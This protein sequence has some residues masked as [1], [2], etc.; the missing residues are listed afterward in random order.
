M[1][2]R[3]GRAFLCAVLIFSATIGCKG[4]ASQERVAA[5]EVAPGIENARRALKRNWDQLLLDQQAK[6]VHA[7]PIERF[8][9]LEAP[10]AGI[11]HYEALKSF[12]AAN[13][14][15]PIFTDAHGVP[16]FRANAVVQQARDA[17]RHS[18][19]PEKY[20]R[21]GLA[22]RIQQQ[23]ELRHAWKQ[24]PLPTLQD[25]D[26][27]TIEQLLNDPDIQ[28]LEK[29]LP[30]VLD[31][32][33]GENGET[34]AI[35][36]LGQA[37]H[38]RLRLRRA[39]DGGDAL[40]ELALADMWLDWAYDMR[41]G[42]WE[43][44]DGDAKKEKQDEIRL[45]ALVASMQSMASA[46]DRAAADTVV[47]SK[48]PTY[49]Q[50]GRL[51]EARVKYQAMVA[52][53][54]WPE[55][56]PVNLARGSSGAV[57][58]ELKIRLQTEGYFHG[59]INQSFDKDLEDAVKSYQE[60]HQMEANGRSSAAFWSSINVSAEDRLAQL[61]LTIQRWRESRI[62]DDPYYVLI[63]IPDFH[64]E[65]WRNGVLERRMKIVVGNTQRECRGGKMV[66]VNATPIQTAVMNHVVLNPYWNVPQRI[67][68]E[69]ILPAF[70]KNPNYFEE[71][72]YEQVTADNGAIMVRQVPG[73]QNAL[74]K[75]KFMFPNEHDTYMHDTPRKV[76]F[77]P[78]MRAFSHGCM[79]VQ[80][81]L[82]FLEHLLTNDE[83][84]DKNSIDRIFAGGREYRMNLRT[85][86]PVHSE[87]YVVRVD[88]EGRVH[89]MADI[90]RHDRERLDLRF[91]REESCT[92]RQ[93]PA[94]LR[95]SAEGEILQRND[96]GE[97][98]NARE[99]LE[100]EAPVPVPE[101]PAGL[102]AGLPADMGP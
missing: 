99:T 21:P 58:E 56:R 101:A 6:Q 92:P 47:T 91:V 49:Q 43:K 11:T 61:E 29:P 28:K 40:L 24:A 100:P 45:N 57:V 69:E 10:P 13:Q 88:D 18:L 85:P 31:Q 23:A 79:R 82:D 98:V 15:A 34:S 66:Y 5:E 84:W 22:R 77:D 72:G 33:L 60:T 102:P 59:T 12:Y 1:R 68:N 67:V 35:P 3:F 17:E 27:T 90:Y 51:L 73:P 37:W 39:L 93:R 9:Q 53:G 83:N 8:F 19:S 89:F 75:V 76:F 48:I 2:H 70:L 71:R 95:L 64:A 52:A 94:T 80:N 44:V 87:Y 78:P 7:H 38:D 74:G 32:L 20:I 55:I 54:G 62:G 97:L 25:S 30:R 46:N 41:D 50:Y 96:A 63:N 16:N 42:Y 65:L 86:I 4:D 26:W 36:Q 14:W 81:P